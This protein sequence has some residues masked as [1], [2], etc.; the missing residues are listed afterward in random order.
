M[1][2]LSLIVPAQ[3]SEALKANL[4][5]ERTFSYHLWLQIQR[6]ILLGLFTPLAAYD[7]SQLYPKLAAYLQQTSLGLV[8]KF[9]LELADELPCK[10]QRLLRRH[11]QQSHQDMYL[12]LAVD[13]RLTTSL[14]HHLSQI[15][16]RQFDYRDSLLELYHQIAEQLLR[17]FNHEIWISCGLDMQQRKLLNQFEQDALKLIFAT[18]DSVFFT[19]NKPQLIA[20][21]QQ[22]KQLFTN[23]IQ[24]HL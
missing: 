1:Q 15:A 17:V 14:H 18:I 6:A 2:H 10:A 24:K 4:Y 22:Q 21:C 3:L 23:K 9:K 5:N 12:Q 20:L 19:L 7:Q 16:T 11:L 8:Q 13:S